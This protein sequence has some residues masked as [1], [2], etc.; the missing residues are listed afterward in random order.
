MIGIGAGGQHQGPGGLIE[1]MGR[2]AAGT[3][4]DP[5]VVRRLLGFVR[6]H[7][8]KLAISLLCTVAASGLA[9]ATPYLMKV[10]IDDDITKGDLAGLARTAA[11][12]TAAFVAGYVATS[13]QRFLLSWIGQRVLATMRGDLFRKIQLLSLAYHDRHKTGVTISRVINDV[14]VMNDLLSQGLVTVIADVLLLGG[15]VVVMVAMSPRLALLAFCVLPLMVV[16]TAIFSRKARAAFRETRSKIAAVVGGL[17][18]NLGGMRVIQAF[19]HEGRSHDG[20]DRVN[21][22]NMQANVDAMSLSFVFMP[23][24]ELLSMLAT[25]TVLWFGGRAVAASE[26]S[27]GVVVAFLSYVARFFQPVQELSQLYTTLQSAMAGGERVMEILDETPAVRDAPGAAALPPVVG[28][29]ELRD[30]TFSYDPAKP[31]LRGISFVAEPG[32]TVAL[33]GP[34]GAGKT[35]IASLI[36]RFYDVDQGAVLVDGVDVRSVTQRSLRSQM[37][38]V[39]QDPHLFAGTIR[40]NISFGRPAGSDDEV[41]AAAKLAEVHGFVSRLPRGYE[42]LIQEGGVNLSVGQRQLIAVAR[43]IFADPRILIMD[44]ATSSVDTITEIVIQRAIERL[45]ASR[46]AIVIA[47]RLSTVRRASR[48]HVVDAGRIVESGTH[49]EL[50]ERGGLYAELYRRLDLSS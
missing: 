23:V 26:V 18:E 45:L 35:S 49:Q 9:L 25:A 2:E 41:K 32:E 14:G 40:E 5:R 21:R 6:P 38:I 20:F 31:V 19:G 7:A 8:G 44:E 29:I 1:G 3:A 48:I 46:T 30:V 12:L 28:R 15:I 10:A 17:A 11:L 33:V 43:A 50:V 47:H 24:V 27:L 16:A 39:A 37:G 36:A 13:L 34:T 42:T 22:E 4:F